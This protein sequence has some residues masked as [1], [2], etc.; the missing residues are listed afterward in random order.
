MIH[1]AAAAAVVGDTGTA[2]SRGRAYSR[3]YHHHHDSDAHV[4]SAYILYIYKCTRGKRV[5][6]GKLDLVV[7]VHYLSDITV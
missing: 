5:A 3:A 1:R 6:T 2:V 4:V 7:A